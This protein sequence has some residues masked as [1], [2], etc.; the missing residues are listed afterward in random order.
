MTP[1][2]DDITA[3]I[4]DALADGGNRADAVAA[5]IATYGMSQATAYRRVA[6]YL[7]DQGPPRDDA[8]ASR[9]NVREAAISAMLHLLQEAQQSGDSDLTLKRAQALANA[10]ARL[11]IVHVTNHTGDA[12]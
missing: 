3:T 4:R 9:I 1:S 6:D 11:R 2:P 10:A 7:R 8:F 5:L 12:L